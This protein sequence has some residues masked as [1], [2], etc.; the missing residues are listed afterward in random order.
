MDATPA[1]AAAD[2]IPGVSRAL[3]PM[4]AMVAVEETKPPAN[5]ASNNPRRPPSSR[6][7]M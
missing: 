5:P 6:W 7:A 4:P 2:V 3:R 1:A